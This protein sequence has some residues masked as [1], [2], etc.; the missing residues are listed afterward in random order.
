MGRCSSS[1]TKA[2]SEYD[3]FDDSEL[4][5]HSDPCLRLYMIGR[6]LALVMRLLSKNEGEPRLR[7]ID[8]VDRFD[9]FDS[10]DLDLDR[11]RLLLLDLD[12]E[13]E[14]DRDELEELR[15]ELE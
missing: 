3:E 9:A 10:T 7:G 8:R 11:D 1:L 12:L 15:L 14:R 6:F 13:R 4:S 5:S 2:Q